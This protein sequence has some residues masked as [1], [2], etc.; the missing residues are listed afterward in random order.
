MVQSIFPGKLLSLG[1]DP[2]E[3]IAI[4]CTKQAN[5]NLSHPTEAL[6]ANIPTTLDV[7]V[8]PIAIAIVQ[9]DNIVI[10]KGT[11]LPALINYELPSSKSSSTEEESKSEDAAS[12]SPSSTIEIWQV[13][14]TEKHL[15]TLSDLSAN[16]TVRLLLTESKKLRIAVGGESIVIG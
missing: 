7:P 16:T 8:S 11:P 1:I 2:S 13:K 15:A 10:D 4:G 9:K 12:S 14:P 5:W 3:A 6:A